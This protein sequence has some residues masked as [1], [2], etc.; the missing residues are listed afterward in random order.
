M[1]ESKLTPRFTLN[2]QVEEIASEQYRLTVPAGKADAY[3]LAQLDDYSHL[4]RRKFPHHSL[5]LSL[6]ARTSSDSIPGTWGFGLWNDP[7]G[8]S[9]GFGGR[10][11]RFPAL[12]NAVWFFGA[13]EENY[14]SFRNPRPSTTDGAMNAPSSAQRG[15]ANG[16]MAQTFRAPK[17]HPLL[18]LA[19]LALPFSRKMTRRLLS[20]VIAEDAVNLSKGDQL[21]AP[22]DWHRYRLEWRERRVLF[23]V[24]DVTVFESVVSPNHPLGLVIWIDNQYA[25]FTPEGKIELG[26]LENPEPAWLEIKELQVG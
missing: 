2:A 6:S 9:L 26:V 24:D 25:A 11:W 21:V 16:F 8:L 3:R 23:E 14:L 4:P 20:K 17:F 1:A 7:F 15:F 22:T 10:P 12:P 13:S 18:M 5:T 19:G